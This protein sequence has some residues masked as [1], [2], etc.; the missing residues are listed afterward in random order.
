MGRWQ[1]HTP[2]PKKKVSFYVP[3][4]EFEVYNVIAEEQKVSM[5]YLFNYWVRQMSN[6]YIKL[7]RGEK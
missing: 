5:N 4:D 1:K 2:E 6:K 7:T 3:A